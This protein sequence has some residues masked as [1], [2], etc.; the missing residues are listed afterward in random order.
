MTVAFAI[1]FGAFLVLMAVLF[2]FVLRFA[3]REG[4]RRPPAAPGPPSGQPARRNRRG[5]SRR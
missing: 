2:V 4:R 3:I 1:G 5:D